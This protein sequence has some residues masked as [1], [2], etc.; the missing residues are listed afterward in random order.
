MVCLSHFSSVFV[1]RSGCM[2]YFFGFFGI[3]FL[4]TNAMERSPSTFGLSHLDEQLYNKRGQSP[5]AAFAERSASAAGKETN[6]GISPMSVS[7]AST[8]CAKETP[9]VVAP[10][11]DDMSGKAGG[12]QAG[13]VKLRPLV[14][15]PEGD[16]FSTMTDEEVNVENPTSWAS[17]DGTSNVEGMGILSIVDMPLVL[18]AS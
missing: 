10:S 17:C 2:A 15:I 11:A 14:P 12:S 3:S 4:D 9:Q 18:G 13:T 16:E 6:G 8:M 5:G 1:N 7:N